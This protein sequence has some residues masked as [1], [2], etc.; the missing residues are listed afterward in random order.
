MTEGLPGTGFG[1]G[2]SYFFVQRSY[3]EKHTVVTRLLA[4]AVESTGHPLSAEPDAVAGAAEGPTAPSA[5]PRLVL[6]AQADC[7]AHSSAVPSC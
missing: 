6:G 4:V 5:W 2:D 7:V 3:Q 1:D